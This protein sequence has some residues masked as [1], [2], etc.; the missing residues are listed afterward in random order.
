MRR[1]FSIVRDGCGTSAALIAVVAMVLHL[2]IV[3]PMELLAAGLG[4]PI[5]TP[6]AAEGGANPS[7]VPPV[8]HHHDDCLLCH[9]PSVPILASMVVPMPSDRAIYPRPAV[10]PNARI[11]GMSRFGGYAARAPPAFV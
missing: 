8:P 6:P 2:F 4:V 3:A 10:R 5:C 1:P 9:G 7:D 11:P